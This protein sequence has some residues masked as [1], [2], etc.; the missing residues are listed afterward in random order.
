MTRK[1]ARWR[2]EYWWTPNGTRKVHV[3]RD[4]KGRIKDRMAV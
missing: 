1:K 2:F 4:S 3:K